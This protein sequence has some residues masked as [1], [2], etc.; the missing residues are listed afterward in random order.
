MTESVKSTKLYWLL[1]LVSTV[2]MCLMLA[3]MSSWFWVCLP[4]V[5]TFLVQALDKM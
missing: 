4:F 2:I 5:F 3:F 1:F